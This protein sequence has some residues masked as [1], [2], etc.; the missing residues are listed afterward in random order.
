MNNNRGMTLCTAALMLLFASAGC[1]GPADLDGDGA[2][3][4]SDNCP[5]IVNPEQLDTDGD[6]VGDACDGD[7]DGDGVNDGDDALPLNPNESTDMDGDGIGDNSDGDVDGDGTGNGKD[8]FPTDPNESADTDGDGIGDNA[9]DDDDDDGIADA[10][11][12][13]RLTPPTPLESPG[14][15]KVGTDDFTFTGSTGIEITVQAWFPTADLEGEEVVYDNIYPGGAW[16]GAAP[17][18][19]QTHPVAIYSHGTGYGLRWMSAFL[20][21]RLASHGFLV[22][23]PDHVDDTLFD[24]DSAKLPQT[25]LRRPVDISD[26]FDWMVEKS[27]G[28]REFRG[29]IDPSAGYAVMGHSGGGYTALTTSGATISIDDLE[30]DCGAGIDFYCSMRDT[31][32]ESHPGSDTIDLSDDRVWATV[33]LAP[34]D[35]FVLGTGLRMVRTP[36]LVLTGDADATTNLSM[37]MAIVA[38]LDDPSALFGVLKNAGHYHFSPIGCDAYGCEGMLNLSISKEFTNESVTLF[39]AQQLQWPGASE[40]SMPESA[41]VEWR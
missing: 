40:L 22:I 10:S 35:G 20:T 6:G 30:E 12:P 37:V 2:P 24:S 7:D 13:F 33:A 38:D 16:D 41:Y 17:D 25:L 31:W 23:A 5:D 14:P 36:T 34:W 11:D 28:N 39:L 4:E 21:E 19:S 27:E 29:C 9:D 8:A 32:L 1:F 26:T 15:F 3:D 18:C